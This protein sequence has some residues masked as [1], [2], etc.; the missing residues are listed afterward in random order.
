MDTSSSK[1]N[2]NPQTGKGTVTLSNV[3]TPNFQPSAVSLTLPP[4][5]PLPPHYNFHIGSIDPNAPLR[6]ARM[7]RWQ[8]RRSRFS[9]IRDRIKRW[10]SSIVRFGAIVS[11][12]KDH[13]VV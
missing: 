10:A 3:V 9:I 11:Y 12:R 5:S 6:P 8:K 4:T 1:E 7:A 2:Y 13:D